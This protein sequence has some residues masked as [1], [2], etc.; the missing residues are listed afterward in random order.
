[1]SLH[2]LPS[3]VTS[4]VLNFDTNIFFISKITIFHSPAAFGRYSHVNVHELYE[5]EIEVR[6][7]EQCGLAAIFRHAKSFVMFA[8]LVAA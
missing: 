6:V 1:M 4:Q 7:T 5:K 2:S 8:Y 3:V